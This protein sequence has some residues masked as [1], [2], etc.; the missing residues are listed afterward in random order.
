MRRR[1][2]KLVLALPFLRR[3]YL[4][5][6]LKQLEGANRGE[7]APELEQLQTVLRRVPAAQRLGAL[8]SAL[9]QGLSAPAPEQQLPSRQLRRAATRQQRQRRR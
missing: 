4:R 8:E 2:A 5:R 7:L 3:A 6:L 9:R 1:L